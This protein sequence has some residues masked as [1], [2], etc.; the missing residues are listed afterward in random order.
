M[1]ICSRCK[2]EKPL[3]EFSAKEYRCRVCNRERSREYR[4]SNPD[5]V[6]ASQERYN[7]TEKAKERAKR[8]YENGGAQR[9]RTWAQENREKVREVRRNFYHRHAESEKARQKEWVANNPDAYR[10][11]ARGKAERRRARKAE[12]GVFV[13]LPKEIRWLYSQPC[14][15]CGSTENVTVDHVIPLSRGGRHSIGNLQT[16][17]LSCNSS[18]NNRLNIEWRAYRASV[19]A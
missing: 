11:I 1:R 5:R 18:K 7:K 14:A 6:K 17:C 10:V 3:E 15:T 9:Q 13:V 2:Q 12:A 8:F 4:E 19:A 16:L